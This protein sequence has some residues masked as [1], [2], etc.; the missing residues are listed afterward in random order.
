MRTYRLAILSLILGTGLA[1][2]VCSCGGGVSSGDTIHT[3]SVDGS[4]RQYIVHAPPGY[5]PAQPAA[6]VLSFHGGGATAQWQITRTGMNE[7]SDA[8]GFLAVYPE[9]T[10]ELLGPGRL[11][12]AGTC[13]GRAVR[14]DVDDVKFTSALIDDLAI[15]YSIDSRRVFATGVSN[16]AMMVYR[17]ACELSDRIAAIAPVAGTLTVDGC[18]PSRPISVIHFHGTADEYVPYNGGRGKI[19]TSGDFR[20]VSDTI[21]LFVELNGCAKEP[22]VTFQKG[23]VTCQ[24]FTSCKNGTAITLC[25]IESGGHT[26]PGGKV[27]PQEG[28]TSADI[29]ANEAMWEFFTAHPMP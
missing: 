10:R 29:S 22:H 13:C 1:M 28:K 3:L 25:L 21:A 12:N 23:D 8:H 24:S 26:W 11:W 9:G 7:T 14:Q 17:L 5:S 19:A 18:R 27:L 4:E 16:G 20:S 2:A 15:R 6:V